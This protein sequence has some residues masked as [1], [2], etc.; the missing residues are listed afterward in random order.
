SVVHSWEL[1]ADGGRRSG[2]WRR[3]SVEGPLSHDMVGV[4]LALLE[5]LARAGVPVFVIST[6][7]TDHVLVPSPRL[8]AAVAALTDAGHRVVPMPEG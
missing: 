7:D 5:P 2:P 1:S 8:P 3:L 6:F 4:L